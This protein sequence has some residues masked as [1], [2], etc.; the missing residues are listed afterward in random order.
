MKTNFLVAYDFTKT[1]ETAVEHALMTAEK[2]G[3]QVHI[4]HI[5]EDVK[6]IEKTEKKFQKIPNYDKVISHVR[7]GDI[8]EDIVN[9]SHEIH[10]KYTFI[11]VHSLNI[12]QKYITGSDIFKILNKEENHSPFIIVQEGNTKPYTKILV[13]IDS[14]DTSKQKLLHVTRIAKNFQSEVVV[15]MRKGL[16]G[17]KNSQKFIKKFFNEYSIPY[18][19][20]VRDEDFDKSIIEVAKE[21]ECNLITIVNETGDSFSPLYFSDEQRLILN[22]LGLPVLV[23]NPVHHISS[24]WN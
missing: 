19:L 17:N 11:G 16:P 20:E 4:V 18:T 22:E 2:M 12:W 5:I 1:A 24:F 9:F 14:T 6:D 8:F 21:K 10:A 3:A 7:V 23:V 13:P 15:L